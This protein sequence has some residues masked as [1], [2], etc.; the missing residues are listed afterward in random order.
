MNSCC[1]SG[2]RRALLEFHRSLS[3]RGRFGRCGWVLSSASCVF[4]AV[5]G[6]LLQARFPQCE[7]RTWPRFQL[8]P[9]RGSAERK[10]R[11]QGPAGGIPVCIP[12]FLPAE[13][14]P[15]GSCGGR[16]FAAVRVPLLPRPRTS[17]MFCSRGI[18]P[19][20]TVV[21]SPVLSSQPSPSWLYQPQRPI[22]SFTS[23][24]P[25]T[26]INFRS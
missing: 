7:G 19:A 20:S 26:F 8:G 10:D 25:S 9:A 14:C 22:I 21:P 23:W 3:G 24:F 13:P 2:S 6:E 16:V 17:W 5:P 18:S 15:G 4:L 11:S 1:W 12:N